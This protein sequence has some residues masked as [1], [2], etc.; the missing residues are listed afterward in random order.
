MFG[1][2][3]CFEPEKRQN[4]TAEGYGK[5]NLFY[6]WLGYQK[7]RAGCGREGE[8]EGGGTHARNQGQDTVCKGKPLLIYFLQAHPTCPQSTDITNP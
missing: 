2:F 3:H 5:G 8:E 4:I 1:W 7:Q 6:S